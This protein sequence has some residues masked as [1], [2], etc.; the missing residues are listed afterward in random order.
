MD[1]ADDLS[2]DQAAE[3]LQG[4]LLIPGPAHQLADVLRLV[5]RCVAMEHST[6]PAL[7]EPLLEAS[8]RITIAALHGANAATALTEAAPTPGRPRAA[9]AASPVLDAAGPRTQVH[10]SPATAATAPAPHGRATQAAHR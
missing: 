6:E 5:G 1:L 2:P 8:S 4:L 7:W 10:H 9:T 3:V